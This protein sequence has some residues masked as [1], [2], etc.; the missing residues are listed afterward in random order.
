[1]L[2]TAKSNINTLKLRKFLLTFVYFFEIP[3]LNSIL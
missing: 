3:N 2:K 1:M